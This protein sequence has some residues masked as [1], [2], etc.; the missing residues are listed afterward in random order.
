MEFRDILMAG[1]KD[2]LKKEMTA[3]AKAKVEQIKGL[4]SSLEKDIMLANYVIEQVKSKIK[5]NIRSVDNPCGTLT[6][7]ESKY[8]SHLNFD[9]EKALDK[10]RE[11]E[12]YWTQNLAKAK[13]KEK[14]FSLELD[15]YL[16][17]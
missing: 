1:Q 6:K 14:N 5:E 7:D 15:A 16:R 3:H 2:N 13:K 17:Q 4:K 9:Y 11:D 8:C 12:E 10:L